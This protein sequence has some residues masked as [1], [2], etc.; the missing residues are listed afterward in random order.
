MHVLCETISM[1]EDVLVGIDVIKNSQSSCHTG[2]TVWGQELK[3]EALCER[4]A[5]RKLL[6]HSRQEKRVT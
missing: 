2:Q 4:G 1:Y 3:R 6:Q 5:V